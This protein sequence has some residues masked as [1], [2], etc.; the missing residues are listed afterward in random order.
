MLCA[1]PSA[2]QDDAEWKNDSI[3]CWIIYTQGN[4]NYFSHSFRAIVVVVAVGGHS[5]NPRSSDD[6]GSA[7][8]NC[9][10]NREKRAKKNLCSKIA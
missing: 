5:R 6:S 8:D 9:S 1:D 2:H 10:G 4:G 7:D 3:V